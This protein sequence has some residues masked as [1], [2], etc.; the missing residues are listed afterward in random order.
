MVISLKGDNGLRIGENCLLKGRAGIVLGRAER[1]SSQ[2]C[3]FSRN[4]LLPGRYKPPNLSGDKKFSFNPL[5]N[6][7]HTQ[8]IDRVRCIN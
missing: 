1:K 8:D 3:D 4:L 7:S 5:D 6:Y 2:A